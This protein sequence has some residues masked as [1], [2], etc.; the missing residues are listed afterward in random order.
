MSLP[1]AGAAG[2]RIVPLDDPAGWRDELRGVP[3]AFAHTWDSCL[4][5]HESSGLETFL[6]RYAEEGRRIVCPFAERRYGGGRD[7][8]TPY[9]FSGFAGRG[10]VSSSCDR[11][12]RFA[13][14]NG[15]VAA[16]IQLNPLLD[17]GYGTGGNRWI[18]NSVYILDL[19]KPVSEL[20]AGLSENRRREIRRLKE[21]DTRIL[22][23]D[24]A[25]ERFFR[26]RFRDFMRSRGAS[27]VYLF[28]DETLERLTVSE[29]T[30]LVAARVG[31]GVKAAALFGRT[32]H[33]GDYLFNVSTGD[34]VRH[35]AV[36]VWEGAKRLQELGVPFLNLGGGVRPDDGVARFKQRFGGMERPLA[37]LKEVFDEDRFRHLCDLAGVDPDT[38]DGYFPPYH[39]PAVS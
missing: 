35:S 4:A 3:H 17:P 7:L 25:A 6:Y 27:P 15:Y 16:F 1:T 20:R 12:R 2:E 31:G 38:R 13:T 18:H 11:W 32:P 8:V 26:S 28:S 19:R 33:V 14:E 36:L 9:G 30:F 34:G 21:E 37:C 29:G 24:G 5:M 22:F 23:D 39:R 10:E